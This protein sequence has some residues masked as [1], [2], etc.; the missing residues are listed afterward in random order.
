MIRTI[1]IVALLVAVVST[2]LLAGC[3]ST[4]SSTPNSLSG[5]QV[6]HVNDKGRVL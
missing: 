2:S 3:A 6:R 4:S 5:E 1:S